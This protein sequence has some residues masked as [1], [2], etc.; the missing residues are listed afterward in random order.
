MLKRII[1]FHLEHRWFVLI[2]VFGIVALGL[3]SMLQIPVDA[4]PDLTNNQVVVIVQSPGMAPA[5][6]EQLIT[7][8]IETSLMGIP[9]TQG[10]RS[11]SKLG[12]S[13]VTVVFDD[14]VNTY[15]ARQLVNER[16]QEVRA[17]MPQGVEPSLGPVATAFGEVFQYTLEGRGLSA[18]DLKTLQEWQIKNQLRVVPGVNEINTWGGETKQYQIEVDPNRLQGYG[19]TLRDVYERVRENNANFGG[20]FIEHASEQ[21][22]VRG[23]GRPRSARDLEQIVLTA[24]TGT[25]V[26]IRDVAVVKEG[27]MPRQGAVLRDGGGETVSGMVI[28]L[29][30]ENGKRVIDRVKARLASIRLPAWS[31]HQELLRSV[32]RHRPDDRHGQA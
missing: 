8:P 4:F 30:G 3:Y 18:M 22:T 2:G 15:F 32:L 19:L 26:M 9:K 6:V 28:M 13:I 27:P 24:R 12:L 10:I 5:D 16:L 21:Y 1:D 29:K 11:T 31:L 14:S 23:L 17:R 7:F 20:G 25:P